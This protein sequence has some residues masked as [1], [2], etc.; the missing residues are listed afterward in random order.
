M[1]LERLQSTL[2]YAGYGLLAAGAAVAASRGLRARAGKLEPPLSGTHD[3]YRWRGMDVHYTEAGDPADETLVCVHGINAA[4]S[5][6]EF[7]EIVADLAEDHHVVAPDL[8]GFGCSDR[9]SLRYSAALYEDFLGD[10][11]GEYDQPAVVASS[12]SAAYVVAALE[13]ADT[14]ASRLA[15]ICPTATG[16]PEPPKTWLRELV[17]APVVGETIFNLLGSEPS[18]RYFNADHGYWNPEKAGDEWQDYEWRTT[19]QAGARF[20]PASFIAGDL[21]SDVA[22]GPALAEL[23]VPTTIL[24]GREADLPPLAEGRALAETADARLVVFDEAMLLP[25]V[26]FPERFVDAVRTDREAD[27]E[28]TGAENGE[29]T[30][31]KGAGD[32]TVTADGGARVTVERA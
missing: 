17:R 30:D 1:A 14:D 24:W 9:P 19:H 22:L 10:F 5:S 32:G 6:G 20:A 23:D 25:H 27:D 8:P 21:N 11:L 31:G 4:G 26:E 15:L 16:G 13:R 12:L 2:R 7:R 18:I 29:E 28:G 3:S